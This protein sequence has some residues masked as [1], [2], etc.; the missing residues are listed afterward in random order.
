MSADFV[1]T[2]RGFG[3]INTALKVARSTNNVVKQNFALAVLYNCIAVPIAVSG[4]VTPLIAA[5]A[6]SASSLVVIANSLRL[7]QVKAEPKT[8]SLYSTPI[9][10]HRTKHTSHHPHLIGAK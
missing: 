1:F 4:F 5:I 10:H 6:M 8:L 9:N 2:G 3:A 7:N